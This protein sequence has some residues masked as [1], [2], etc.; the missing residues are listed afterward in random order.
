MTLYFFIRN[1][2]NNTTMMTIT[3]I[4]FDTIR[5]KVRKGFKVVIIWFFEN[6]T[7]LNPTKCRYM[8]GGENSVIYVKIFP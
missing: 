7:I 2:Y 6:Y 8:S 4:V 1:I 3:Y 5:E